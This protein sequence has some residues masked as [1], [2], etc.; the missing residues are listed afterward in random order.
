MNSGNAVDVDGELQ[1]ALKEAVDTDFKK[2]YQKS[3]RC[4]EDSHK[5]LFI[6][7]TDN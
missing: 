1:L 7:L 4:P 6:T 2:L 5:K 3:C